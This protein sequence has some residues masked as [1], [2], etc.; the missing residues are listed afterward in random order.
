MVNRRKDKKSGKLG[1][2]WTFRARTQT[3]WGRPGCSSWDTDCGDPGSARARIADAH[4]HEV[5]AVPTES[6]RSSDVG[7]EATK[8]EEQRREAR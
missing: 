7:G 4:A 3:G 5:R 6:E 1:L 8:Y 2:G